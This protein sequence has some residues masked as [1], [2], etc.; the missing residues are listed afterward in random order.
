[1]SILKCD[2][3][4]HYYDNS[5]FDK[6]PHCGISVKSFGSS[7][8][9]SGAQMITASL[10]NNKAVIMQG[11]NFQKAKVASDNQKESFTKREY[12]RNQEIEVD[13]DE[14]EDDVKTVGRFSSQNGN[15]FVTGWL[16][17][18]KGVERGT[19]YTLRHGVNKVGRD[20]RMDVYIMKDTYISRDNHCSVVYE[21]KKNVFYIVPTNG[22]TYLNGEVITEPQWLST[23]DK[24]FIGESEFEFIAYC[25]EGVSWEG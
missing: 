7:S 5:K 2:A 18:T 3:N 21:D 14:E 16:V 12:Y 20:P 24:I 13:D 6:C 19:D 9:N 1:M 15:N 4:L 22:S 25:R 8:S 23:G 11:Q 17:C 10:P